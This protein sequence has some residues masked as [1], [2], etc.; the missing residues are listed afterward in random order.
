M[1]TQ[2][3]FTQDQEIQSLVSE[4]RSYIERRRA[5]DPSFGYSDV[6]DG[7]NWYVD[8]VQEGGGTLGVALVGYTYI[9]EQ[10]GIRFLKL[11][12]F[13]KEVL[14]SAIE[15]GGTT[16]RDFV[17]EDGNPGYFRHELKVYGRGGEP[18]VSCGKK[19]TETRQGQRTTVSCRKCQ[20]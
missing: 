17:K 1:L 7:E 19:L 14:G 13:I 10:A 15:A 5:E 6:F 11:A 8:L 20:T 9:M 18:C 3:D 12:G 16:L 4:V 2:T